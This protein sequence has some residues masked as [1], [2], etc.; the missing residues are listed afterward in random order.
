M[1]VLVRDHVGLR[2]R[3]GAGA[4]AGAQLVEEAEVDVDLLVDRAV[5]RADIGCRL[6]AAAL[7]RAGEEDRLR[8]RVARHRGRPVLLHAVDVADDPTLFLLIRV[9]PRP[10]RAAERLPRGL[11]R[12]GGA[13]Q[14]AERPAGAVREEREEQVDDEAGDAE[15][16][17][18]GGDV[19]QADP[20]AAAAAHVLDLRR[21]QASIG[22]EA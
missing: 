8:R 9:A 2:E 20:A 14:A 11:L 22:P 5:E 12:D 19:R 1:T 13:V 17:A 4:E 6:T 10:A 16:A 21:V 15:A 3:A 18:T 7:C